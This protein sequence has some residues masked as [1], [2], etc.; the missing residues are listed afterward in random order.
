MR[1]PAGRTA[2]GLGGSG[3]VG[4]LVVYGEAWMLTAPSDTRYAVGVSGS[5][6]NGIWMLEA[7]T[8]AAAAVARLIP[9]A[10]V[11]PQVAG[12]IAYRVTEG[13]S[14]T[15]TARALSDPDALRGQ[16]TLQL[17]R[18]V[19]NADYSVSLTSLLGPEPR[20]DILTATVSY[21]F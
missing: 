11:R 7:G 17:T 8:A 16:L 15:G 18:S 19:G 9:D 6:P 2:L 1:L 12:Q 20:R 14:V 3:L 10:G 4:R 13:F 21:S 5:I